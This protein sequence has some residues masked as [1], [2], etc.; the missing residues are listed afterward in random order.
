MPSGRTPPAE[1]TLPDLGTFLTN[2]M[3][4]VA[5]IDFFAVPTATFRIL[6]CSWCC[7]M[8][9]VARCNLM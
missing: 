5:A 1:A 9:G 6:F 8:P 7:R 3:K 4:E 2:H